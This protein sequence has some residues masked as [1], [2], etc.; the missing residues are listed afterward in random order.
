MAREKSKA[1]ATS[2]QRLDNARPCHGWTTARSLR[3]R[4]GLLSKLRFAFLPPNLDESQINSNSPLQKNKRQTTAA[5]RTYVR[6][7]S[8]IQRD[9]VASLIKFRVTT[10][11]VATRAGRRHQ[12][13]H[14]ELVVAFFYGVGAGEPSSDERLGERRRG[15]RPSPSIG[16][17]PHLKNG[18]AALLDGNAHSR[19][20]S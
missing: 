14:P 7:M 16:V 12:L 3:S 2:G 4:N 17:R 11:Q 15:A 13:T 18:E 6:A 20:S 1:F 5:V 10:L 8:E 19:Q 9:R